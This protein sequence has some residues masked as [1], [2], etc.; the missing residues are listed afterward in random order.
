MVREGHIDIRDMLIVYFCAISSFLGFIIMGSY[1]TDVDGG[2]RSG[3][4]LFD[5]IDYKPEINANSSE[6][7]TEP[8]QG[9]IQ[10]KNVSFQ[11]SGRDII[12]LNSISFSMKA[13]TTLG[14]TGTTGSG[15][16]TIAQL[17][18]R[19]YDPTE[20]EIYLDSQLLTSFNIRH[21]RDS[22]CWVGQEPI[23]FK[24]SIL[25]NLQLANPNATNEEMLDALS[26]AQADDIISIYGLDNDV[27]FRESF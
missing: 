26:R 21:L 16:S 24:G 19:F 25:Y 22:I 23:L 9:D 5:I 8:I 2:I 17:L 14:I 3:K 10:F 4:H 11:Y 13:G 1:S 18:L 7:S 15:K 6:G 27:G 12:I 20:G